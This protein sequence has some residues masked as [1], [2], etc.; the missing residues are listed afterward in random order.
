[1]CHNHPYHPQIQQQLRI[2]KSRHHQC[3]LIYHYL[4]YQLWKKSPC[5]RQVTRK[6]SMSWT[7]YHQAQRRRV[8]LLVTMSAIDDDYTVHCMQEDF[9]KDPNSRTDHHRWL[10]GFYKYLFT[11]A[12]GFHKE[13]NRLQHASQ[14]RTILE[15]IEPKGDDITIIANKEG[16][17]VW[18][19]WVVPNLTKKAGGTLK[20]YLGSLQKFLEY[21][22]KK[23]TRSHLPKI[24]P[25]T[26]D[27]LSDLCKDLKGWRRTVTKE[28]SKDSWEKYLK[29]CDNILTNADV[30]A[31]MNSEPALKGRQALTSAEAD[32][33]LTVAEYC[34]ARDLL[35]M[36]CMKAVGSRLSALSNATLDEHRRAKWHETTQKRSC[37]LENINARR[38][39]QHP[40]PWSQKWRTSCKSLLTKLGQW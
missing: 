1:M 21:V 39:A 32:K 6:L 3:Y 11:P 10:I 36:L 26:K 34:A 29:D 22:T 7:L 23:G 19:N 37:W 31:I 33:E 14:V 16:N 9:F 27:A 38:M 40:L 20:S 35:I 18:L 30:E 2:R 12:A 13:R 25:V 5:S 15:E 17:K 4:S 8:N 24:D 28:T